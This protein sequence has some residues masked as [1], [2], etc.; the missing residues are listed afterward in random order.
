M[1]TDL[2][3]VS[4]DIP[5]LHALAER[6]L[7]LAG[8]ITKPPLPY[9]EDDHLGF[10]TLSF[11]SK[12]MEHLRSI[13]ILVD[14]GR[15]RDAGLIARVMVEGLG[16]LLWAARQPATRPLQ[17]RGYAWVV[18]WRLVRQMEQSGVQIDPSRMSQIDRQLK[19]LGSIMFS[20][21]AQKA[22]QA[23]NSLPTDP[24]RRWRDLKTHDVLTEV[25]GERLYET[26]YRDTSE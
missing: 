19:T 3:R 2:S 6:L 24:C 5:I 21:K 1:N 26:I 14:A 22:H 20:T 13:C 25:A 7:Q 17:W 11:V 23:G 4:D 18:D 15:D 9:D 16:L 8:E 12:Q 10:M